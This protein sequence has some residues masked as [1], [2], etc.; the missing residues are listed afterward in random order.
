MQMKT[1][2]ALIDTADCVAAM[3]SSR[4]NN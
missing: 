2:S 1:I 3:I 4:Q